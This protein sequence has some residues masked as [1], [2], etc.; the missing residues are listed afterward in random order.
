MKYALGV[1]N[2]NTDDIIESRV[3]KFCGG[4][5]V[6][7]KYELALM[8]E[9]YGKLEEGGERMPIKTHEE[10]EERLRRLIPI[11]LTLHKTVRVRKGV[12]QLISDLIGDDEDYNLH[13][14]VKYERNKLRAE[15]RRI[16]EG[17]KCKGK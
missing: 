17:E 2:D 12:R 9:R 4:V 1:G 7:T 6:L 3:Y 10:F 11:P 8:E 14:I 13:N 16:V 5:L 15:Q